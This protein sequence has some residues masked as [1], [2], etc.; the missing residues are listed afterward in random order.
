MSTANRFR[1]GFIAF[2]AAVGLAANAVFADE[3]SGEISPRVGFGT[4]V[5]T[6]EIEKISITVFPDGRNLPE[7]SGS[8]QQ[9]KAIYEK[10]CTIC[11]AEN[12]MGGPAAR[13]VG[14][15]GFFSPGD[16]EL[17]SRIQKYPTLIISAGA[18]WAYA[19]TFFDYIR[20]AMPYDT[21]KSM[22]NNEVYAV[23]AYI[24]HLNGLLEE[25]AQIDKKTLPKIE[26]PGAARTVVAWPEEKSGGEK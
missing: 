25:N 11:H 23:T 24:L 19:T 1:C 7:G 5:S 20:R 10:R 13:L 9:G 17:M 21:P 16:P 3:K 2:A 6:D 15:E 26:M 18:Q 22:T 8:V 14:Q 4:P 12:G